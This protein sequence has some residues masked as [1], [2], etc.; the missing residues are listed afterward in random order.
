MPIY[1]IIDVVVIDSETFAEYLEQ[2]TALVE[3]FGGSY[4]VRGSRVYPV[5]GDWHPETMIL[6]EFDAFEQ[7][8]EYLASAE[9]KALALLGERS[10]I[11]RAIIVEGCEL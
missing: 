2:V 6:I 8:Q 7:V 10:A 9:Y 11:C 5:A 4:L 3:Q 1:L